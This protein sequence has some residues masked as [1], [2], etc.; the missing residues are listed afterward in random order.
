MT[1]ACCIYIHIYTHTHMFCV[2]NRFG[3]ARRTRSSQMCTVIRDEVS[4]NKVG[5]RQRAEIVSIGYRALGTCRNLA[6]LSLMCT[7]HAHT[8]TH[9]S[10]HARLWLVLT[11][12]DKSLIQAAWMR[13]EQ[14]NLPYFLCIHWQV[15]H[16]HQEVK[17]IWPKRSSSERDRG[18]LLRTH[19][20]GR[21]LM[22]G[23]E[24]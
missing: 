4:R 19:Q 15:H 7:S 12:N 1:R 17:G 20:R 6:M 16:I 3:V 11:I 5:I 9:G 23:D 2:W 18:G 13:D 8:Q 21:S 10:S 14:I 24:R 22:K